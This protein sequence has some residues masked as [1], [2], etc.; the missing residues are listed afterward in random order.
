MGGDESGTSVRVEPGWHKLL[1]DSDHLCKALWVKSK[2]G[3]LLESLIETLPAYTDK[4]F[5]VAHRK[6]A[7]GAWKTEVWTRRDFAPSEVLVAPHSSQMKESHLTQIAHVPLGLPRHGRGAY[8]E[9]SSLA[10]DG[11]SRSSIAKAGNIDS[12]VHTGGLFWVITRTDE[13]SKANLTLESI[14]LELNVSLKIPPPLKK[15]KLETKVDWP[16]TDLPTVPVLVNKKAIDK[17]TLLATF[18]AR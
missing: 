12:S 11:R 15:A 7:Q 4:D 17:H 9:G 18:L 3:V 6:N 5:V 1:A 13:P 2:V 10:L 14:G 16:S 8:P